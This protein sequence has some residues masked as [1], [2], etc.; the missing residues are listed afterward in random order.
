MAFLYET[1]PLA[2]ELAMNAQSVSSLRST[3]SRS[4]CFCSADLTLHERELPTEVVEAE[5]PGCAIE[6]T[7]LE[8]AQK[9]VHSRTPRPGEHIL[10]HAPPS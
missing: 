1:S 2:A 10:L 8:V 3:F 5:K 7:R 6:A 9:V 4:P